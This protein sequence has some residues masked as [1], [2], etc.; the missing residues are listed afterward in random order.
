MDVDEIG[1]EVSIA[2]A[3]WGMAAPNRVTRV[4]GGTLN[5][6]F[7]VESVDGTY[8]LRCYRANLETERIAGEHDLLRL[9]ADLNI[10]A[11]VPIPT[12]AGE[13]IVLVGEGRWT[14]APW[15]AGE[16]VERRPSAEGLSAAQ[17]RSLGA[18]QGRIQDVLATH[19]DSD[20]ARML[21]RW[22]KE[23]SLGLLERLIAKARERREP[24]WLV[25]GLE[26]QRRM[27]ETW[28]V[29][30]PEAYASLPCQ[31]LHGDFHD[32]QALFVG[33]DVSAIVDWEIWHTDPRAWDLVRS[34]AFSKVLASPRLED[35]LAGYREHMRLSGSEVDLAMRLWFQSRVVGLWAW[36]AYL[37]EGNDRVAGFFPEMIAE[38]ERL[39]EPAWQ[40]GVAARVVRAAVG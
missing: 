9:V 7:R 5:S 23:Q 18:A 40:E 33:D 27:L 36:W 6:N 38:L 8:F 26:A 15:M 21:M 14:L 37:I 4:A 24:D 32:Q 12:V 16:P 17:A 22:D 30:P 3:A 25:E 34:L 13:T 20:G 35:Y 31:M 2:L 28:D 29:L 10:P 11:P 39:R 19:P 1:P